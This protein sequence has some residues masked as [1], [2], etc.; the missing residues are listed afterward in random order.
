[1]KF[2]VRHRRIWARRGWVV[3]AGGGGAM[4]SLSTA[5]RRC[6]HRPAGRPACPQHRLCGAQAQGIVLLATCA[7]GVYVASLVC[8]AGQLPASNLLLNLDFLLKSEVDHRGGGQLLGRLCLGGRRGHGAGARGMTNLPWPSASRSASVEQHD[9]L[10]G[11]DCGCNLGSAWK[12]PAAC[13]AALHALPA[14]SATPPC[15]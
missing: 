1:M 7:C 12:S 6:R 3:E 8:C 9:G 15:F 13:R 11:W 4:W 10:A 5:W 14:M 2:N